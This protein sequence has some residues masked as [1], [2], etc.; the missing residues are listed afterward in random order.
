MR[1]YGVAKKLGAGVVFFLGLLAIWLAIWADWKAEEDSFLRLSVSVI[2]AHAGIVNMD[3]AV[4]VTRGI[5]FLVGISLVVAASIWWARR[6]VLVRQDSGGTLHWDHE[7]EIVDSADDATVRRVSDFKKTFPYRSERLRKLLMSMLY[8]PV[9][10]MS[11]DY[12]ANALIAE[13]VLRRMAADPPLGTLVELNDP[14]IPVVRE[15]AIKFWAETR[16]KKRL[17]FEEQLR[18]LTES[19]KNILK[20]FLE[21]SPNSSDEAEHR[22]LRSNEGAALLRLLQSNILGGRF[23][24]GER[25]WIDPDALDLVEDHILNARIRR[26]SIALDFTRIEDD[27]DTNGSGS[28][29]GYS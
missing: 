28:R 11:F 24:D 2:T 9:T 13:G 15:F 22:T 4:L 29:K 19:A 27:V 17:R 26:T 7:I 14:Y 3:A 20:L 23:E 8:K 21:S 10:I 5:L 18:S 25:I 16:Q 6:G 1:L 12:E